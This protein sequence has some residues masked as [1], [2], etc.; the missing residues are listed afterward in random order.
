LFRARFGS[1][2]A[3]FEH[4]FVVNYCP[5]VFVEATGCNR[6]PDKLPMPERSP[7]LELCDEHLSEVVK[8]LE[9]DWLIGIGRF[10][11]DR[12]QAACGTDDRL[13]IGTMLH[14]SPAC[15]ASNRDWE[16][17]VTEQLRRL[18]VWDGTD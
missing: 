16:G 4:H 2:R 5:L 8:I 6:T 9:P 13:R 1:A 18:G 3:F 15:P 17:T 7:L 11:R 10:A 14:P 12:A